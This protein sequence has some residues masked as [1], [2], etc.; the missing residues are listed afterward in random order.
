MNLIHKCSPCATVTLGCLDVASLLCIYC[1]E[2]DKVQ[3]TILVWPFFLTGSYLFWQIPVFALLK[4]LFGE[5]QCPRFLG[6][7]ACIF[8]DLFA[9]SLFEGQKKFVAGG[10]NAFQF[11]GSPQGPGD[12]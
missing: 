5:I 6:C 8:L 9:P 10:K 7:P 4:A 3:P 1:S 2:F 11:F 12:N